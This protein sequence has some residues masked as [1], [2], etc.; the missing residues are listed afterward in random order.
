MKWSRFSAGG[1]TLSI[2]AISIPMHHVVHPFWSLKKTQDAACPVFLDVFVVV[3]HLM[4][5][6]GGQVLSLFWFAMQ[7]LN[8][9]LV[10]LLWVVSE[11][12]SPFQLQLCLVCRLRLERKVFDW[13][14]VGFHGLHAWRIDFLF[15]FWAHCTAN[16]AKDMSC[17][18]CQGRLMANTKLWILASLPAVII[19]IS[20]SVLLPNDFLRYLHELYA[21]QQSMDCVLAL[22]VFWLIQKSF[23]RIT[24]CPCGWQLSWQDSIEQWASCCPIF[25]HIE[26]I[27]HLLYKRIP[28]L[29]DVVICNET[30]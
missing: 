25:L 2:E 27:F 7:C 18:G 20:F 3:A 16:S 21:F 13:A 1:S 14:S 19:L 15:S 10:S 12:D 22:R 28:I 17:W 6:V 5:L 8:L 30:V 26:R 24:P 4:F 9:S 23:G 29:S 11:L